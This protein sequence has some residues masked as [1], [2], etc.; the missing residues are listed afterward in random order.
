M[1][2]CESKIAGKF[3]RICGYKPKQ[4]LSRKWYVNIEDIDK[5][6]S[7]LENRKTK[8]SNLVLKE[9]ALLYPAE[10]NKKTSR[11]SHALV[12]GDY[13]TGYTHTDGFTVLYR[14]E[15]ERE[16][17]QELVDGARVVTIVEKVDGGVDG[18][19]TYEI[20][21]YESGMEIIED[22]WSSSEN[23]GVATITCA[24]VAGEEE[25]TGVKL[26][27]FSEGVQAVKNWIEANEYKEESGS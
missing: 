14:G 11:L 13:S 8:V 12:V 26:L 19:L 7:Q 23:G 25:S 10:G 3:S 24:T 2:N 22:N 27:L 20:A 21:G 4:G 9:G 16:R 6:A 18:E 17:I 15:N 1:E 5:Q